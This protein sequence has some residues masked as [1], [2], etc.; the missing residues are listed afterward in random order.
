MTNEQVIIGYL[1]IIARQLEFLCQTHYLDLTKG[2]PNA[3][4]WPE[5]SKQEIYY[6]IEEPQEDE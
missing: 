1:E 2:N 3:T 4:P 5:I 6:D